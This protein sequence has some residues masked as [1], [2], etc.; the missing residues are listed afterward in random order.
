MGLLKLLSAN[1]I[2][3]QVISFLI[4]YFLLRAF[5]WKKILK[6]LDDRKERIAA[7]LKNIEDGKTEVERLRLEYENKLNSINDAARVKIQEAVNEG[8]RLKDE[9]KSNACQEAREILGKAQADIKY[10]LIKAKEGL[11]DEIADLVLGAT[12]HVLEEKITEDQDKRLVNDF[13]SKIDQ[14]K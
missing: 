10:E 6:L 2:V 7:E 5:A 3:A 9:I 11:K 4:L 13:I 8:E 14:V 12:E 1:E